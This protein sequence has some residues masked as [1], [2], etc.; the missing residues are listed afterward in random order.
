[1]RYFVA[2][3]TDRMMPN[4][5]GHYAVLA[6]SL[7]VTLNPREVLGQGDSVVQA[8]LATPV[9]SSQSRKSPALAMVLS[10]IA[11][12][13]GQMYN[14]QWWKAAAF[15][16]AEI[17]GFVLAIEGGLACDVGEQCPG[18]VAGVFLFL[19][20]Y[21]W[22]IVDAPISA[23]AIN[24]RLGGMAG[25]DLRPRLQRLQPLRNERL[26]HG[27]HGPSLPHAPKLGVTIARLQF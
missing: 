9:A 15:G 23:R 6:T 5:I 19:G 18:A 2:P 27:V 21:F 25:I 13:G 4:S 10:S 26:H 22:S 8:Q 7:F 3:I 12:G 16:G 24:R 11:P 14:Q 20:S 1:M 17:L